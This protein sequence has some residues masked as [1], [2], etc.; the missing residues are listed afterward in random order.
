MRS[1]EGLDDVWRRAAELE[2][3]SVW[4]IEL[5]TVGAPDDRVD[6]LSDDDEID[7]RVELTPFIVSARRTIAMECEKRSSRRGWSAMPSWWWAA[8]L[9]LATASILAMLWA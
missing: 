9:G 5:R 7:A 3:M 8:S 1:R 2:D 4:D 6:P